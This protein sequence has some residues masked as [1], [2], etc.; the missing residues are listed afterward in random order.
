[1]GEAEVDHAG[2]GDDG[3]G[4]EGA[5]QSI[6]PQHG[7]G[8]GQDRQRLGHARAASARMG[9]PRSRVSSTL[10]WIST[11]G[12]S[13]CARRGWERGRAGRERWRPPARSCPRRSR[14]GSLPVT[15]LVVGNRRERPG[16]APVVDQERRCRAGSA[17]SRDARRFPASRRTR[18]SKLGISPGPGSVARAWP[19]GRRRRRR[20]SKLANAEAGRALAHEGN[21]RV[22][23]LLVE[24][25]LAAPRS[26]AAA[27]TTLPA[28]AI[29]GGQRRVVRGAPRRTARRRGCP[30]RCGGPTAADDVEELGVELP[31]PRP[32]AGRARRTSPRPR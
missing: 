32:G 28:R 25:R 15:T 27:S 24:P 13:P 1:M 9:I 3:E 2:A 21:R 22:E 11:P 20:I 18:R 14:G 12:M 8:A 30:G 5:A 10:A 17:G 4:P 23:V 7:E 16:A 31:G 19:G 26:G 29:R 6:R